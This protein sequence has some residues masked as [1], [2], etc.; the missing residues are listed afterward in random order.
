MDPEDCQIP[1]EA[2]GPAD[3]DLEDDHDLG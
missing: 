1:D 2:V 3:L